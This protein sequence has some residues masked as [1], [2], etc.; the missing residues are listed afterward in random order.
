MIKERKKT[1]EKSLIL[2]VLHVCDFFGL[3][4]FVNRTV[5]SCYYLLHFKDQ[6]RNSRLRKKGALDG[7]PLPPLNIV[8]LTSA[9]YD[10]EKY[11]TGGLLGSQNIAKILKKN[12]FA[13]QSFSAILDFGC[14]CGRVIRYWKPFEHTKIY[15]VDINQKCISWCKKHLNF[16]TFKKND[17]LSP[18]DFDD[19]TFD[20]IYAIS[21]FTHLDEKLQLLWMEEFKRLLKKNGVLLLTVRTSLGNLHP[22]SSGE[23][24]QFL[25]GNLLVQYK[26]YVGTNF[27]NVFH[28]FSYIKER[29][30]KDFKILDIEHNGAED[31]QQ[32]IILLKKI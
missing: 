3:I 26:K 25:A 2:W 5:R 28:P 19:E 31:F 11:C 29:F 13:I 16:A 8:Y 1:L 20:C 12:G 9:Y 10:L 6:Q 24:K 7:L 32:D 21:V 14:G 18:L 23:E 15:G 4:P 17:L 30:G 22:V 27:C